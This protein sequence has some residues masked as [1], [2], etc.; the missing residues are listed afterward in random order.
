VRAVLA[1]AVAVLVASGA[2]ASHA[3]AGPSGTHGCQACV[4][5]SGEEAGSASPDL[6]PLPRVAEVPPAPPGPAP[7]FGAPLGAVPGQ[8]PPLV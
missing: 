5:G 7:V 2:V 3:H 4:A 8:S 1:L 6:A